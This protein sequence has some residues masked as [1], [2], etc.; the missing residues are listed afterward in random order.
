M[1]SVAFKKKSLFVP[2]FK[3]FSVSFG[4]FGDSDRTW[5]FIHPWKCRVAIVSSHTR[6]SV[7][8]FAQPP[9]S[10]WLASSRPD[11]QPF[12]PPCDRTA[13][14]TFPPT[15]SSDSHFASLSAAILRPRGSRAVWSPPL[16]P[17]KAMAHS[18]HSPSARD[19]AYNF[20]ATT[21]DKFCLPCSAAAVQAFWTSRSL[22][23]AQTGGHWACKSIES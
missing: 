4:A 6:Q 14:D 3:K 22:N 2:Y 16:S 18:S 15:T 10:L 23:P 5:T 8:T 19:R 1:G 12:L 9:L 17:L 7:R 11:P 20:L 13:P 21:Q